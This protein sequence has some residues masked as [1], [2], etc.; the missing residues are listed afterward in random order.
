MRLEGKVAII[1]GAGQTRGDSTG[2]GRA[3]ALLFAREGAKLLLANQSTYSLHETLEPLSKG[4]MLSAQRPT[5]AK[6]IVV[7]HL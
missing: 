3:V 2:N 5:S 4:S 1:A 7:R 6:R